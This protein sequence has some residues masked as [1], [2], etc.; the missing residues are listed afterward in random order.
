MSYIREINQYAKTQSRQT[1]PHWFQANKH[2][3]QQ[4]W[5]KKKKPGIYQTFPIR[6][7]PQN[8]V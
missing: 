1:I 8:H 2:V 6:L 7:I 4:T 3:L 5:R